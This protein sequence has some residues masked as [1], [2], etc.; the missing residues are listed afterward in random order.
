MGV[1]ERFRSVVT[2]SLRG[3][4]NE[5]ALPAEILV[6]PFVVE[7]PK[8]ADHGDL[9]TNAAL[10]LAKTAKK[11][12]REVATLLKDK[13]VDHKD[14]LSVELAGPG[15][16]NVRLAPSLFQA[17]L[18]EVLENDGYGHGS[19]GTGQ[20]VL[21]EFVSANPTGPL[22][23]SHARGA[24]VG[25]AIARLLEASGDHVSR[26]YYVNDFGNQVKLF[27]RSVAASAFARPVPEGGYPGAYV[28]AVARY[29]KAARPDLLARHDAAPDDDTLL[30]ELARECVARMLDG[31]PGD[32]DLPGIRSTLRSLGVAFDSFYSEESL[33]RWGRVGAALDRLARDGFVHDLEDGARVFRM[34]E[35]MGEADDEYAGDDPKKQAQSS[36]GRVV[37][38]N[39]GKTFTY[40]ASDIAYHA[41]KV[42]RG[43]ARLITVLGADHHGYVPRIRNVLLALGLPADRFEAPLFQLV[44]LVRDGKPYKMGKRLGNLITADEVMEEVDE[45]LGEGAGKDAIRYFYLSRR[46]EIPVELDV[47]LAKR[48]SLDNPAIYLQYGHARLAS[49]LRRAK[50]DLN[51]EAP[52]FD[53]ALAAK[54]TLPGE[55]AILQHLGTYPRV[56]REAARDLAPSRVLFYVQELAELFQAYYTQTKQ[57]RDPILP[58]ASLREQ[59]G[60]EASWDRDKTLARLAWIEGIRRVYRDAL[61]LLGMS[62]PDEMRREGPAEAD[63][64]GDADGEA[65]EGS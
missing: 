34:P 24:V 17:V 26:E 11:N 58:M 23:V 57:A 32:K 61:T 53:A 35:G 52:A 41:D 63:V 42:D 27:A 60:W 5:G 30:A 59:A 49:I 19:A 1:E 47:E 25:D 7:K 48:S 38:K 45:A 36:G 13:L 31:V 50:Q 43:Y 18:G 2:A 51:L 44:S 21:I 33:H 4:V 15:F 37:R 20:R 22:L 56:V 46:M 39:D 64:E 6:S 40:F 55:L 3:L 9:S 10:A 8:R 14:I 16:L 28:E 12:P 29:L 65:G 62:A 54:L